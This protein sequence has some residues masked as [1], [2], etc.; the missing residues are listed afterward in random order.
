MRQVLDEVDVLGRAGKSELCKEIYMGITG[1][2]EASCR[3][4]FQS[5]G[6]MGLT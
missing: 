6:W 5:K 2:S 1:L 3:K 4:F